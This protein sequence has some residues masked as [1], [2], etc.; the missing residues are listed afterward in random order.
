MPVLETTCPTC[1]QRV[2]Q[3]DNN[4]LLDVPAVAYHEDDSP[5]T[6][7]RLGRF[8]MASVGNP[9]PSGLGHVLHEHQPDDA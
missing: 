2:A 8:D 1:Q 6:I 7:M 9:P 3:C 5:W 4:V